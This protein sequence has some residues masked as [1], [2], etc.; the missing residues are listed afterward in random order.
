M[1]KQVLSVQNSPYRFQTTTTTI[2]S[3]TIANS[4]V[5]VVFLLLKVIFIEKLYLLLKSATTKDIIFFPLFL[6]LTAP[7]SWLTHTQTPHSAN[8]INVMRVDVMSSSSSSAAAG[9][10]VAE[11]RILFIADNYNADSQIIF[12]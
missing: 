4:N 9:A 10:V 7:W 8:E 3:T 1:F 6:Y 12:F 11:K 5:F 2:I